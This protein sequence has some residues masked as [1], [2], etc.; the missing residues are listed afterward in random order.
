M[1]LKKG[2]VIKVEISE[3]LKSMVILYGLILYWTMERVVTEK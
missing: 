3:G 2:A 1:L